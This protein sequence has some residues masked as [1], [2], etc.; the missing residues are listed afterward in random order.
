VQGVLE[1]TFRDACGAMEAPR[2]LEL[3]T[4]Q[5][6]PP[7]STMHR[8]MVPHAGEFLG[9][10]LEPGPD[11]DIVADVHRLS[12]AVGAESFDVILS[13]SVF[14]HLKYPQLA[15]HELMKALRIGGLVLVV[16]HQTYPV[17]GYPND[18]FRFSTQALESL[19]PS[20]MGFEVLV[21]EYEYP[22]V[23]YARKDPSTQVGP[24]YLLT[25]LLA[26]KVE[27]TPESFRYEL[28]MADLTS[29]PD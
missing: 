8:D 7:R 13:L 21:S 24:S 9:T 19:F 25:N 11:V 28:E 22:A 3:G 26:R 27:A 6:Q 14:E 5:S 20:S 1:A 16:T 10:D 17:H 29:A 4:K 12:D 23:I 15:A 18:Y 2:V